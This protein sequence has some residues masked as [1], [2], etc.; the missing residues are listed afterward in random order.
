MDDDK[1]GNDIIR[2]ISWRLIPFLVFSYI[3]CFVDR[4]NLGFAALTM[5]KEFGFSPT[6][7][8]WGAGILFVGYFFFGVPSNLGLH[9]YGARRWIAGIMI[10]WGF[11]STSMIFI[12]GTTSFFAIRFLLGAAEAGFFPGIILYLTLWFPSKYRGQI[13]SRFMFAQPIALMLGS[14]VSGWLLEMDGVLGVAGWKW[15]FLL[16]GFP[17][18]LIGIVALF[19]LTDLPAKALWLKPEERNW[20][21]TELDNECRSVEATSQAPHSLWETIANGRVLLLCLIYVCM[22]IGV[23]GVNMWLPQIV[24]T[25]GNAG[26]GQIGIVAAIPFLAASIGMLLIGAS[27]DRFQERKWHVTCSTLLAGTALVASAFTQQHQVLTILLLSI[28]S[29]GMYGCMPI[30][31]TIP[32]TFLTGTAVA[33]GIGFINAIG[34]LG[35]FLGPFLVGYIKDSTGSFI[36]GLLFLGGCTVLGSFLVYLVCK[37]AEASAPRT[38]EP[39]KATN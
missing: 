28:S 9:K 23:Y 26:A 27:S 25:F 20:L 31:W 11:V 37:K 29:I 38:A 14:A 4:V 18:S 6:V 10:I 13:V 36:S 12:Q 7:F 39:V 17:S 19:F 3:L 35:G 8:G 24:K 30:F 1:Y 22:V 33:A 16:E 34:N 21:Q 2:K 15:L 5:N 32:P